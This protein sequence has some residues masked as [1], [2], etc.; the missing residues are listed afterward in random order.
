MALGYSKD[1]AR[2]LK[3]NRTKSG[4][5]FHTQLRFQLISIQCRLMSDTT[6]TIESACG[7]MKHGICV[8]QNILLYNMKTELFT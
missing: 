3:Q 7:F 8:P 5:V 1:T 6:V 4:S 2:N